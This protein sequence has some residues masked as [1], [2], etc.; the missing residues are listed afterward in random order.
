MRQLVVLAVLTALGLPAGAAAQGHLVGVIDADAVVQR[1]N[2]GKAFLQQMEAFNQQ[3]QSELKSQVDAFQARQ[4][5][6][7]AAA[8]AMSDSELQAA[9]DELNR[10][11]TDLKRRQEDAQREGRR[12]MD[13]GLGKLERLIGPLVR[14]IAEERQLDLV[15]RS[16]PQTPV[17]YYSDRVDLTP[18]VVTRLDALP[19]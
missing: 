2:R 12:R 7:Q 3:K 13:E 11:Q 5:E 4:K 18:E 9:Q 19:Q 10:L 15:V 1:S 6:L 17:V 8:A 16:G 14:Q